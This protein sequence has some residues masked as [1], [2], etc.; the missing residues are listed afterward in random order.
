[1]IAGLKKLFRVKT[2][3]SMLADSDS[4]EHRLNKVL[5]PVDLILLGIG[6][7]VGAGIFTTI[8][9]AT[10]G[11]LVR[12][13]AGPAI[14]LSFA[15]TGVVCC[16]AALCYAEL[17][18]I[19]PISGS[20]YS[21][22]YATFGEFIAWIIGWD[23]ILE[24]CVG[25]IAVS[26]GWAAYF[27][28]FLQGLGINLPVWA[29]MDYQ[30]AMHGFGVASAQIA[31]G[32][33]FSQLTPALQIAFQA[34]QT[35]PH[36][37]GVAIIGNL[38]A[39]LVVLCLTAIL[40]L[41]IK[42][43]ARFNLGIVAIKLL[44]LAFFVGVG[45]FFVK[46][47]N[48]IPFAPNGFA[49]IRAGAAIVFFAFIGFDVVST[50]AEETRNPGKNMPIG[51]IGSLL[52]CTILYIIV[53]AVFTGIVPFTEL[54]K[55]LAHQKAQ[56]LALAM[57][58]IHLNASAGV[59]AA[60]S[61]IALTAVM[62]ALILGQSRIFFSMSRD[63]LLPKVFSKVHAKYKTPH[64]T[65]MVL[66]VIIAC[67]AAFTNIDEMVDLTNIGTL[68]AFVLVCLG[69][70]ILRYKEPN[71]PRAFKVPFGPIVIP[72][73]GAVSSMFLMISLPKI[74]WIRF[75]VWLAIGLVIYVLYSFRNSKLNQ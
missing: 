46:T 72:V 34:V 43:S 36:I 63:G 75:F 14:M 70:M 18:A 44:V 33:T 24:Y 23:L 16:F 35:A 32:S 42:E 73:L 41:G 53:A 56:P 8:G 15:L 50:T 61:V 1:M 2:L 3:K 38:P 62:L 45:A 57:Q 17:A 60:G 9:T 7:I 51:I 54:Q 12:P 58:Y 28:V 5:G 39:V 27:N 13:G 11:D 49:G 68:F 21:Y 55:G 74:T 19:V 6:V 67:C 29:I 65:T 37:L 20:A 71:H 69:V 66:G 64:I 59:V 26:I 4:G 52:I 48:W 30:T 40:I 47:Q 10:A 31:Q 25:S 22:A